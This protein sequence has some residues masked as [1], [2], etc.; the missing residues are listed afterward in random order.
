M[1]IAE[2]EPIV[3]FMLAR[4]PKRASLSELAH[5][6]LDRWPLSRTPG[7]RFWRLLGVGQGRSFDPH[8]DLRRY[9]LF[10]VWNSVA[11][12]KSFE[13]HSAMMQRIQRKAEEVW[14][15]QM[16]PIRW[17]G[18]W[19]GSDPFARIEP[20]TP[21][22]KG[23]WVILTRASMYP[24]KVKSFLDAVP[25]VSTHLLQ[26]PECINSVGVGE[27]PLLY[28]A[29][30]SLWRSLPAVTSFAYGANPHIEVVRRTHQERWYKEE[31]F[32]RFRPL[33]ASGTWDGVNPLS[34][35]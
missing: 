20:V 17:H 35:I 23:P 19:G 14:T 6:G 30:L 28:Q 2:N 3:A 10:T 29:T 8:A 27:A 11:A 25:A 34:S 21:P 32:A 31:L 33:D 16:R 5:L 22:E 18:K 13:T 1:Q 26:Q 24:S 15:V 12:L 4:Y 7:L 9:A